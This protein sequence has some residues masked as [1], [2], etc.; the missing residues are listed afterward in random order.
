MIRVVNKY[1]TKPS[2]NDFYIG[3]GSP[4]GNPYTHLEVS[5]TKAS[6]KCET[7]EESLE[8]YHYYLLDNIE[9]KNPSICNALNQIFLL[10]QKG[11]VNLVCFCHPQSCHGDII[12]EIIESKL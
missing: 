9:D 4:L 7:R 1:K 5:A 12:K 6:Y 10:A 3:R 2:E 8:R 11:D